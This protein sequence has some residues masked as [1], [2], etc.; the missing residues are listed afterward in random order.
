MTP[1]RP[2]APRSFLRFCLCV[3]LC[4]FF[5]W[6]GAIITAPQIPVWYA[7]LAKPAWTPPNFIFP[8]VWT[9]LYFSMAVALWRL[10]DRALASPARS[11]ALIWFFIQ[12]ALNIIWTPVFFGWHAIYAGLAVIVL[13]DASLSVAIWFAA[14]ADRLAA[15]LLVPYLLW[16]CYATAL[17]LAIALMNP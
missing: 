1:G 3:A 6:A 5:G 16:L 12:L 8:I 13:L 17:N 7:S 11:W 4:V 10:W 9:A 15:L 2:S 14:R